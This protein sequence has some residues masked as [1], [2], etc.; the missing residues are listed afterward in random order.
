[1]SDTLSM[2]RTVA[3][4]LPAYAKLVYQ[5]GRPIVLIVALIMSIPGE[6]HLAEVAGWDAVNLLGLWTV[7]VAWGMPVCVSVY[8]A[9]SAVIADVAKRHGLPNRRS[10]MIGAYAALALALSAQ[11]VSH[12]IRADFMGSSMLLV[13]AVSSIPPLVAFHMLHMAA[14]PETTETVVEVETGDEE[15]EFEDDENMASK[16]SRKG[17]R[18]GLTE[19]EVQAAIEQLKAAGTSV[20]PENLGQILNRA[21]RTARRY[22]AMMQ[23]AELKA[24]R[25]AAVKAQ[26]AAE[27]KTGGATQLDLGQAQTA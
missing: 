14:A 18:P 24:Q 2:P 11:D 26:K 16:G 25:E 7:N 17:G 27:L 8:A 23:R 19:E 6:V 12:W 15:D 1:M 10:A 20:T 13:G 5:Y 4:D 22:M 3:V 9:C 21:P